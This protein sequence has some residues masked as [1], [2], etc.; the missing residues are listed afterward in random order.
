MKAHVYLWVLAALIIGYVSAR[1][2]PQV[3]QAVGLP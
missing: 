2:F 1:Y 3:G